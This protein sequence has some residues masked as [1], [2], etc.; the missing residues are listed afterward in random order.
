MSEYDAR[1]EERE[2]RTE[3]EEMHVADILD[4]VEA[5]LDEKVWAD[6]CS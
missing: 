5:S 4:A 1:I 2:G 3:V 6:L